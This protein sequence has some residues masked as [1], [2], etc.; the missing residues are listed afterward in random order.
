MR[1]RASYAFAVASVAAA[2]DVVDG[3]VRDVRL[4]FGAVAAKPWRAFEAEAELRGRPATEESFRQAADAELAAARPL[5]SNGFKI[6]LV[7]NVAARVLAD[8]AG[9]T[10]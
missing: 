4:A 3:V 8:L 10:R 5:R 7:R 2:L 9:S 6:P 1:D